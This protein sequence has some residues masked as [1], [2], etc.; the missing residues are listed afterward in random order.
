MIYENNGIVIHSSYLLHY[1]IQKND[2][3]YIYNAA[4]LY[5]AVC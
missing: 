3:E 2:N 1:D 5:R 4:H